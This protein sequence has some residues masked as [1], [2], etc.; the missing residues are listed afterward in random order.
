MSAAA[1]N[2]ASRPDEGKSAGAAVAAWLRATYRPVIEQN[3][4]PAFGFTACLLGIMLGIL[5]LIT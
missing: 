1:P 4:L 2:T 5:F 3:P